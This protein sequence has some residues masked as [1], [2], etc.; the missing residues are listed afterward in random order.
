MVNS[1]SSHPHDKQCKIY[2]VSNIQTHI[3]IYV[4]T[5]QI[6]PTIVKIY[7]YILHTPIY[8]YVKAY[9]H[10]NIHTRTKKRQYARSHKYFFLFISSPTL[11]REECHCDINKTK[12]YCFRK[13][14]QSRECP[15]PF[16]LSVTHNHSLRTGFLSNVSNVSNVIP[17]K[18]PSVFSFSLKH[19]FKELRKS[20]GFLKF[21]G[22]EVIV[23]TR[24]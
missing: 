6:L 13:T 15:Q 23:K 8:L 24:I 4:H 14:R 7:I 11:T 17:G 1:Q 19:G 3:H 12:V 10:T 22:Q 21:K 18:N 5:F 9:M 2:M 16:S 20:Q